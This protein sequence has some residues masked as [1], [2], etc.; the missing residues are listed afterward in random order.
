ME[1]SNWRLSPDFVRNRIFAAASAVSRRR[2]TE[3]RELVWG[4]QLKALRESLGLFKERVGL[5]VPTVVE[6]VSPD[7]SSQS[8]AQVYPLRLSRYPKGPESQ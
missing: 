8:V 1:L 6:C 3:K 4:Q 7:R 5:T 2:E